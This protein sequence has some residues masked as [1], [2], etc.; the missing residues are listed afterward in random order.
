MAISR[1]LGATV[2]GFDIRPEA[3]EQIRSLGAKSI[4]LPAE[5]GKPLLNEIKES[6]KG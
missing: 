3:L 1:R 5:E 2:E 6:R 4:D